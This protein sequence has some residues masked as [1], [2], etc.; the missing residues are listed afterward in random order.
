MSA[1]EAEALFIQVALKILP[2]SM[3]ASCQKRFQIAQHLVGVEAITLNHGTTLN[4]SIHK[5]LQ[6]L[7]L[8]V[9]SLLHPQ[10]HEDF[11]PTSFEQNYHNLFLRGARPRF[12]DFQLPQ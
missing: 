3:V 2:P 1:V 4:V 12:P 11:L 7:A 6:G 10:K 5:L 8:D 9:R